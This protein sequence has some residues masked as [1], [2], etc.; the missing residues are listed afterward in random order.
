MFGNEILGSIISWIVLGVVVGLVLKFLMASR[1]TGGLWTTLLL[2]IGGAVI[3]GILGRMVFG[4]GFMT[5]NSPEDFTV[6]SYALNLLFAVLGA[7]VLSA[8][9]RIFLDKGTADGE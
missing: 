9:Y 4:F 6:P 8:A 2:G 5:M 7:I 3:G 1:H